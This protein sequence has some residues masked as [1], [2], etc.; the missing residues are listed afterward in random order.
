MSGDDELNTDFD[1]LARQ[2]GSSENVS[3]QDQQILNESMDDSLE[4][5]E[6]QSDMFMKS[7]ADV[8]FQLETLSEANSNGFQ[9]VSP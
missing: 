4:M 6:K 5:L 7:V 8:K 2:N 9:K 3:E 1:Q